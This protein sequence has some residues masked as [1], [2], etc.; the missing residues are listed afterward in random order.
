MSAERMYGYSQDEMLGQNAA[1]VFPPD[2]VG[3]L[4]VILERVSRGRGWGHW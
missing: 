1:R 2:Q 3:E 4:A